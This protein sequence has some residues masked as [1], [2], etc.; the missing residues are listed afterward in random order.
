MDLLDFSVPRQCHCYITFSSHESLFHVSEQSSV[1]HWVLSL[2]WIAVLGARCHTCAS[3]LVGFA[4]GLV[5][6][7]ICDRFVRISFWRTL[8]PSSFLN[9]HVHYLGC[10][11]CFWKNF[12]NVVCL[13]TTSRT[14]EWC[15][16]IL[17]PYSIDMQNRFSVHSTFVSKVIISGQIFFLLMW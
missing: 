16:F 3:R 2:I 10:K 14:K 1:W 13:E 9:R 5:L 12:P 17:H 15:L 4:Y 11:G 7:R 6:S 8:F